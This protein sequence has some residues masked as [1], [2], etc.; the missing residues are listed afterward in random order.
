MTTYDLKS[1]ALAIKLRSRKTI[2]VEGPTDKRVIS[3]LLLEREIS[4]GNQRNCVIDDASLLGRDTSLVGKGNKEKVKEA[5]A[6]LINH[7]SKFNWLVDR[8]WDGLD[9]DNPPDPVPVSS[10]VS[11]GH[12]TRGHSI[13]NYWFCSNALGN[14]LKVSAGAEL[15]GRFFAELESRFLAMLRFSTAIS[16]VAKHFHIITSCSRLVQAAHLEWTGCAYRPN[17][18]L[19]NAAL[20][21]GIGADLQAET[22]CLLAKL[23]EKALTPNSLR[24]LCHGHLG[25]EALRACAAHLA[26]EHG[27]G[28]DGVSRIERGFHSEKLAH[29][30]DWLAIA[31]HNDISPLDRLVQWAV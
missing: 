5:A 22:L 12:Q 2:L 25:E 18:S 28:G 10:S 3:R 31:G 13:E 6:S 20:L 1:Y 16:L 26:A 30:A 14:Y 27:L 9:V 8:E 11:W 4:T 24:W 23:E 19:N 17:G 7:A 29:D 15:T 21:R